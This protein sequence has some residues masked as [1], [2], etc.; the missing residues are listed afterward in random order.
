MWGSVLSFS[1][2]GDG[3]ESFQSSAQ[4]YAVASGSAPD[5]DDETSSA[6]ASHAGS[7]GKRKAAHNARLRRRSWAFYV[8]CLWDV[9]RTEICLVAPFRRLLAAVFRIR[10]P[11]PAA[12][13]GGAVA[14]QQLP[15]AAAE[16]EPADRH[17]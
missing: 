6:I 3:F 10:S 17:V 1:W 14:P 16:T 4:R 2:D 7:A 15:A 9:F 8:D 13:V 11:T 12:A 5:S